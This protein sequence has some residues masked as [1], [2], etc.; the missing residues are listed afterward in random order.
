MQLFMNNKSELPIFLI[1]FDI[2]IFS[3]NIV[4]EFGIGDFVSG[5][6]FD[7]FQVWHFADGFKERNLKIFIMDIP[8][9]LMMVFTGRKVRF[10]WRLWV[11]RS[12]RVDEWITFLHKKKLYFN[13][14]LLYPG[15]VD[16]YINFIMSIAYC[17]WVL[18]F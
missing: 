14:N 17:I 9:K 11:V 7:F 8:S 15:L 5:D 13:F 2:N 1:D 12:Q 3:D 4:D 16:D 18:I 6:N 10:C